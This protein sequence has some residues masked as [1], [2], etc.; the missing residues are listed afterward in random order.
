MLLLSVHEQMGCR[1]HSVALTIKK[2][3]RCLFVQLASSDIWVICERYSKLQ[4]YP[5]GQLFKADIPR[6]N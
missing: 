6:K 1:N 2:H 3:W 4:M 5:P